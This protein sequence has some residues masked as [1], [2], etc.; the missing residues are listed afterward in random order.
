MKRGVHVI[1]R[2]RLPEFK[3]RGL[4]VPEPWLGIIDLLRTIEGHLAEP[5]EK[6]PLGILG[7]DA[8]LAAGR[9]QEETLTPSLR[10]LLYAGKHYF[11][12]KEIPLVFLVDAKIGGEHDADGAYL[13]LGGAPP[14]ALAPLFGR[15]LQ[16]MHEDMTGWW[17]A[18]QLG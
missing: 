10:T 12:W 13:E 5:V 18:A 9:Q 2:A 7:F 4:D 11:E 8:L 1:E 17:W 14:L 16:P 6:R 15:G 3:P